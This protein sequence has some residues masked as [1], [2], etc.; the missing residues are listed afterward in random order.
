MRPATVATNQ[1]QRRSRILRL[2]VCVALALH[3]V[4][5]AGYF[6]LCP[7]GFPPESSRF[8]LNSVLPIALSAVAI[9]GLMAMHRQ[10][11]TTAATVVLFFAMAWLCG[12][13]AGRFIFPISLRGF[14]LFALVIATAGFLCFSVLVRGE[15]QSLPV[16]LISAVLGSSTGYFA[17]WA[18][19]A[20]LASTEPSNIRLPEIA[21]KEISTILSEN[22]RISREFAFQPSSGQLAMEIEGIRLQYAPLL[23]FDRISPDRFWSLF[24]P[25][26]V[27]YRRPIGTEILE[28]KRTIA[29]DDDSVVELSSPAVD[30]SLRVTAF[31][32]LRQDTYS[33]LN[34]FCYFEISGHDRLSLSFSPCPDT[35]IEVLPADY[36]TGRPARLVYVDTADKFRIV[37]ARS[38]EKGP[39][40]QL[41]SGRLKRGQQLTIEL[42]DEGQAIVWITLE[43]WS[44]QVSTDLSPTAGWNLPV[45][46]IQFQRFSDDADSPV[47]IWITLAGTG[48][49]RGWETVGHRA[50]IYRNSV[51]LRGSQRQTD[52][53]R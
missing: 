21:S 2:I 32:P 28:T 51:I 38:G 40:R 41:A 45:N 23:D 16:L 1:I 37:E 36:P 22:I 52:D 42:R 31:T 6:W 11:W 44:Q 12:A 17:I 53:E 25:A 7:K 24:A 35:P 33:H 27:H 48:V 29:Y 5:A 13:I 10:R 50:G 39:F 49:G 43:D 9:A 19:R 15:R 14:W 8:W 26:N 3:L 20:P 47:G 34:T 46:S 18:Q 30:S 4:A